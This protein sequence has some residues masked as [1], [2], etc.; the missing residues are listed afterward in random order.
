MTTN[1]EM[2]ECIDTLKMA[3]QKMDELFN[4]DEDNE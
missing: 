2:K 1:K 3:I 4:L